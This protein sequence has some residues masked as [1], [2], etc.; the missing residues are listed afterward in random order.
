MSRRSA[1]AS[2]SGD[3]DHH[4][5]RTLELSISRGHRRGHTLVQLWS[6]S[7][8]ATTRQHRQLQPA[9]LHAYRFPPLSPRIRLSRRHLLRPRLPPPPRHYLSTVSTNVTTTSESTSAFNSTLG[10]RLD[11]RLSVTSGG[12]VNM[13]ADEFNV[14]NS[15]DNVTADVNWYLSTS[16]L[17]P[18]TAAR[19]EVPWAS[20]SSTGRTIRATTRAERS[21][22]SM[23]P[24]RW[25]H[26]R[27][28]S[29]RSRTMSS[30][31][32]ATTLAS[33]SRVPPITMAAFTGVRVLWLLDG[34]TV[35]WTD[36]V[37]PSFSSSQ[38]YTAVAAD[39]WGRLVFLHFRPGGSSSTSS[40]SSDLCASGRRGRSLR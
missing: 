11:L 32:R 33:S 21:S 16:A 12:Y 20:P 14:L 17:N 18:E 34:T 26:A 23:T 31:L 13:S 27:P 24:M 19:W 15:T 38:T 36:S 3:H 35:L 10:I 5:R 1:T 25:T 37:V 28:R 9:R 6:T 39:E 8:P 4:R 29:T 2:R 30:S 7:C 40:I 22:P